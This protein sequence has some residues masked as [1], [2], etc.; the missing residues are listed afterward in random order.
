MGALQGNNCGMRPDMNEDALSLK[1]LRPQPDKRLAF[2]QGFLRQPQQVGSVIPSSRFLERRVVRIGDVGRAR[3]VVELGPGTGGTTRAILRALPEHGRLLAIE[4]NAGFAALLRKECN[5]ARLVVHHGSAEHLR[6]TLAC[7]GLRHVDVVISGI[8]FST[9]P[10]TLGTRIIREIR[11]ALVPG[12]R[13]V[14][15]QFRDRVAALG[16]G[17]L[18][19]PEVDIELLNVPPVRVYC[20]RREATPQAR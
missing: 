4:I 3:V 17:I 18:G 19:R 14:A 13:F 15:Y 20:W 11:D 7:H 6:E 10:H 16:R 2:L 5:D 1:R 8:P 9:M 12:G